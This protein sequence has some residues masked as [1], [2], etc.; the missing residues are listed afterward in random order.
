MMKPAVEFYARLSREI[1]VLLRGARPQTELSEKL[2]YSFNQVGKWES[3]ATVFHWDDFTHVCE[4]VGISWRQYFQEVFLLHSDMKPDEQSVFQILNL[5][6]GETNTGKLAERL[7]KSR[8][9]VSRLLHGD[10]KAD[11]SEIMRMMDMRP[12]VLCSWLSKF[13]DISKVEMLQERVQAESRLF[14]GLLVTPWAPLVNA[15]LGLEAYRTS[16][17]HSDALLAIKTGLNEEQVRTALVKLVECG[18]VE[19]RGEKYVGL[20]REMTFLRVP[21]FRRVTQFTGR[22]I[23]DAFQASKPMKPNIEN[24]SLSSSR[25]YPLSSAASKRIAE[26]LIRF[27]HEV[28]DIMKSDDGVKDHVRAILIHDLDLELISEFSKNEHA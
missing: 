9:S 20:V 12:Y 18:V 19:K 26:A 15:A 17:E 2:G 16:S 8:S 7:G 28:S 4:V 23:T 5:F 3:G 13:M 27:H 25:V 22:L 21:E 10:V 1:L 6:F 11:F 14:Q 24:P